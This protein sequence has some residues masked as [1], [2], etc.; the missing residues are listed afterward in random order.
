MDC[1][2]NKKFYQWTQ[3][4]H[5]AN[6]T[7]NEKVVLAII[8][9]YSN[10]KEDKK[11]NNTNFKTLINETG[12]TSKTL[13]KVLNTLEYDGFIKIESDVY[14][15]A[16]DY[17]PIIPNILE[18]ING[19]KIPPN[20]DTMREKLP[21]H[22]GKN[23][24]NNEGK[25]PSNTNTNNTNY[26]NSNNSIYNNI[27]Y[28][29]KE[30]ERSSNNEVTETRSDSLDYIDRLEQQFNSVPDVDE[31]VSPMRME[32]TSNQV[33][34]L[35]MASPNEQVIQRNLQILVNASNNPKTFISALNK[36]IDYLQVWRT[37]P[38]SICT[39]YVNAKK[40]I[41]GKADVLSEKQIKYAKNQMKRLHDFIFACGGAE[42]LM[43]CNSTASTTDEDEEAKQQR[44][45]SYA[46]SALPEKYR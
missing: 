8:L 15:S 34:E 38:Q 12:L 40:L 2:M 19:G 22:T 21:H 31:A 4:S 28:N 17:S 23:S 9:D 1:E 11:W 30:I 32:L 5:C 13:R 35:E 42:T 16:N 45:M 7:P 36:S 25:I 33:D 26:N 20:E 37:A 27:I 46:L 44:M 24:L 39:V 6:L 3:L 29:N 10:L 43:E 14:R 41:Q 18:L